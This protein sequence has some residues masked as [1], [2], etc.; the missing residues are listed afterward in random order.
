MNKKMEK[1]EKSKKNKKTKYVGFST[2]LVLSCSIFVLSLLLCLLSFKHSI[3]YLEETSTKY[4]ENSYL[5]YKVY[6]KPNEYYET[7]YLG[8]NM[9]YIASLI[10][11]I[12]IDFNYAFGIED[13][14]KL[15]YNYSIIGR[16]TITSE[17]GVDTYFEKEYTLMD[18][19]SNTLQDSEKFSINES[20][21][22]DYDY[23]NN[24]ANSFKTDY[25]IDTASNLTVILRINKTAANGDSVYLNDGNDM[26]IVIPLSQRAININ[27]NYNEINN[28]SYVTRQSD[29]KLD[30]YPFVALS[31]VFFGISLVSLSKAFGLIASIKTKKSAY[32]KY[33]NKILA[34]YDRL[35][36]ETSTDPKISEANVI[37]INKIEELLDVR[38]NLK[39]PIMYYTVT[40]HQKCYFYIRQNDQVYLY[41]VKAVDI[42]AK[43]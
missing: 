8:K 25:G 2:R 14:L 35:I 41:V 23:Y 28:S 11:N 32:D 26:S 20:I 29:L 10:K 21:S 12:D 22:I 43:K 24:L 31:L 16:L 38:D 42:E 18:T 7:D 40:K 30:N 3:S 34:E 1:G 37:K 15:D 6:L 33:V 13:K 4:E 39:L 9:A 5:D 36:V 19:K 27:L 17:N